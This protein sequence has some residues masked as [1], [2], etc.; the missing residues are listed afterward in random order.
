M[1]YSIE[2]SDLPK[3]WEIIGSTG[4]FNSRWLRLRRDE[5]LLPSGR[6]LDDY[7]VVEVP[8]GAA[9]VALTVNKELILVR[10]Y[11]HGLGQVVL[12]LPAGIVEANEEPAI[13]IGRELQEETG[14]IAANIEYITTLVTKPARMSAR[15]R[16]YYADDVELGSA[17]QVNDSE[18]IETI[19]VPLVEL[20]ALIQRGEIITETSLAALLMV[21]SRLAM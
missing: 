4:I 2:G 16:I 14:Y 6:V 15:T 1:N 8:D 7:F 3:S 11:K 18:I 13:T 10:Q 12:E 19:L 17:Q 21:W 20:S 5:C 9:I